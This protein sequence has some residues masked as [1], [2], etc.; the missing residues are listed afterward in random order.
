MNITDMKLNESK[1][2]TSFKGHSK[3]YINRLMDVGLYLDAN[4]TLIKRLAFDSLFLIEVDDIEI[5]L[6]KKDAIK[7]EVT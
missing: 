5:C 3:D 4:I 1:V 6:R 7:I 2:V